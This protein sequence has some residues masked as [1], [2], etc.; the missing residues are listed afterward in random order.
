MDSI[1][2]IISCIESKYTWVVLRWKLWWAWDIDIYIQD[3]LK[4]EKIN[5]FLRKKGF[6]VLDQ[7]NSKITFWKF[8]SKELHILDIEYNYNDVFHFFNHAFWYKSCLIAQYIKNKTNENTKE[9]FNIIRYLFLFKNT[10]KQKIYLSKQINI[11]EKIKQWINTNIFTQDIS[12]IN[13]L[14]FLEKK[15]IYLFKILKYKYFWSF[16]IWNTKHYFSKINSW[17]IISITWIDGSGKSTITKIISKSLK[18]KYIYG[19]ANHY[20]LGN[21]FYQHT[22]FKQYK[23]WVMIKI[24]F[25]YIENIIK[26]ITA[27]FYKLRAINVIFDRYPSIN[28]YSMKNEKKVWDT[29][30]NFFYWKIFFNRVSH[31]YLKVEPKIIMARKNERS[32]D[33]IICFNRNISEYKDK[34]WGIIINNNS[35]VDDVLNNFLKISYDS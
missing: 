19:G 8:I 20:I 13:Y 11:I 21:N 1:S 18:Y 28:N 34:F 31:I 35:T 16:L 7:N 32:Y 10:K 6:F 5:I 15:Y 27:I 24:C 23:F 14:L 12:E 17:K 26:V 3:P 25:I 33:E 30:I 22:F 4:K 9:I 29:I 2:H